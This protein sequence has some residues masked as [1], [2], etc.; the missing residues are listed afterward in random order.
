MST[1]SPPLAPPK[2]GGRLLLWLGPLAVV[3]GIAVYAYQ[4]NSGQLPSPW[5]IPIFASL[6]AVLILLSLFRRRTVWR[7]LAL[8]LVGGIAAGE[9]FLLLGPMRLPAETGKVATGQ[10]LPEFKAYRTDG[11]EFTQDSLKG[12]QNTVIVFYRGHW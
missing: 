10:T 5:P 12:E 8:L 2:S 11:Q 6:G 4:V 3:A 1:T 7:V 9:W